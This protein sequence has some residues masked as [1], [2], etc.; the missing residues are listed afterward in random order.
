MRDLIFSI[1]LVILLII[2]VLLLY[3][4]YIFNEEHHPFLCGGFSFGERICES[5]KYYVE[6]FF[7][8]AR[9]ISGGCRLFEKVPNEEFVEGY[10]L[11]LI[12][13][14]D[15]CT[16]LIECVIRESETYSIY[17]NR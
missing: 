11:K 16:E 15:N 7:N 12:T 17:N 6:E 14:S 1:L 13:Q 5:E 2:S 10:E 8:P 4:Q 9:T 3:N